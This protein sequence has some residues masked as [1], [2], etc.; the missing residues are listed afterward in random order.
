MRELET[1]LLLL[2]V[3]I[4]VNIKNNMDCTCQPGEWEEKPLEAAVRIRL[5]KGFALFINTEKER[6][7]KIV[8]FKMKK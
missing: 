6:T 5:S 1:F 7:V 8:H 4:D 3:S 2:S